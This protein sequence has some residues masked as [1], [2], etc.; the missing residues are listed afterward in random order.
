MTL[1]PYGFLDGITSTGVVLAGFVIGFFYLRRGFKIKS[2]PLKILGLATIFAGLM[3]LGVFLD[4]MT[5]LGTGVNLDNSMGQVGL[6]SYVWFAP[7]IVCAIWFGAIIE[8]RVKPIYIISIFMVIGV[9]FEI[10]VF[11]DP[12]NSFEF[13]TVTNGT[14]L[15]DY[16]I[17]RF[18]LA[19]FLM[20]GLLGPVMI[21]MGIGAIIAMRKSTG[22]LKKKFLAG[23]GG[24]LCFAI[25]GFMEG[26]GEQLG[27]LI[28]I[29]RIG[30]M[31]S[32][33]LMYLAL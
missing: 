24:I 7:V 3:Y 6:L 4:F 15:T 1:S 11:L 12:M 18:T 31:S 16:S 8:P 20:I 29:V 33:L 26:L 10:V 2:K 32:F 21:F 27:I 5:V 30:Y 19:E 13:Q 28:V 17:R 14:L 9:I 22:I 25:F 23:L